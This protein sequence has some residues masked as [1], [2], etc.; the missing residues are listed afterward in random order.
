MLIFQHNIKDDDKKKY[1][2]GSDKLMDTLFKERLIHSH[3]LLLLSG[4]EREKKLHLNFVY[5]IFEMHRDGR[6]MYEY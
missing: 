6:I 5:L 1:I 4:S 2:S 3:N